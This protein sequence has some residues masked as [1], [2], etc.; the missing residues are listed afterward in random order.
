LDGLFIQFISPNHFELWHDV[1]I[2]G[3]AI[4]WP[5]SILFTTSL[6][7]MKS[8]YPRVYIF[9]QIMIGMFFVPSLLYPFTGFET[10]ATFIGLLIIIITLYS[11]VISLLLS[12]KTA[13]ARYYFAA[14]ALFIFGMVIQELK[15]FNVYFP[16]LGEGNY[17][18]QLGSA[19]EAL[20]FSLALGYRI[21][22]M[23]QSG[24]AQDTK[25]KKLEYTNLQGKVNPHFLYN[26][27]NMIL[28][29]LNSNQKA[30]EQTV[31]ELADIYE[32]MTYY[33]EKDLVS[34]R[35]EWEFAAKY[36]HIM[37]KRSGQKA[38]ISKKI[39]AE[40]AHFMIPP[41]TIQPLIEN[42][43]KHTKPASP[44]KKSA[45]GK[46]IFTIKMKAETSGDG[47]QLSISDN[48]N[49]A[50]G[51]FKP[52]GALENIKQRLQHYY[53]HVNVSIQPAKDA[54]TIVEIQVSDRKQ[55]SK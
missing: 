45:K 10:A 37:N 43:L 20:L 7:Q 48:G 25:I 47:L 8:Y 28:G 2:F 24:V 41:L 19:M 6:L 40:A 16:V 18:V 9:Y 35:E 27:L 1:I 36:F 33:V 55:Y 52:G 11:F 13:V 54:G 22:V 21:N 30:A 12:F 44:Q 15:L 4:A 53:S 26:S 14:T 23:R 38:S 5:C 17:S 50:K 32:Y 51:N 3:A 39:S 29:M 34:L 49:S 46:N 31:V 42:C